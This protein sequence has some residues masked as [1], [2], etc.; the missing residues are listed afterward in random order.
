MIL[1]STEGEEH[2][3]DCQLPEVARHRQLCKKTVQQPGQLAW[4][5]LINGEK[6]S[7]SVGLVTHTH[8]PHTHTSMRRAK[9]GGAEQ[10]WAGRPSRAA[11]LEMTM[12]GSGGALLDACARQC[13]RH[14]D[15]IGPNAV[16]SLHGFQAF[17]TGSVEFSHHRG[18]MQEPG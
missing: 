3:Q 11:S 9:L 5:F 18:S 6:A 7:P 1:R 13:L 4:L 16:G 17:A 2:G 8:T 10:L 15:S 14:R 12:R